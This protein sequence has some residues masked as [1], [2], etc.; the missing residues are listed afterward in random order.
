VV[1]PA[2]MAS[3]TRRFRFLS[4]LGS[5][6]FGEV[7]LAEMATSSGFEKKVA[8]KVLKAGVADPDRVSRR[9]RD[10]GRLLGLL[11]HP[12]IVRADDLVQLAGQPA[13]I[14]E[15]I[16]GA[17]LSALIDRRLCPTLL[18]SSVALY[19][20]RRVASALN[21]A[22]HSPSPTTGEPL[23]VLH[24]DIKPSNIRVT[25]HGEVKILDF[26]I[27]RSSHHAREA[28]TRDYQLGSMPYMAPEVMGGN[29]ASPASDVYS[30]GA[31][32]YELLGRSRLG[33]A[34]EL[35]AAHE[36][37]IGAAM[38]RLELDGCE[39][40]DRDELRALLEGMLLFDP[41]ARPDTAEVERRCRALERRIRGPSLEE[42]VAVA[43][44]S[45]RLPEPAVEASLVGR[46]LTEE[47]T[48]T[49]LDPGAAPSP[50]PPGSSPAPSGASSASAP[51]LRPPRG[52][53]WPPVVALLALL[54]LLAG[55]GAARLLTGRETGAP[56]P[57]HPSPPEA[58]ATQ[59]SPSG[60]TPPEPEPSPPQQEP[61]PAMEPAPLPPAP[62]PAASAPAPVTSKPASAPTEAPELTEARLPDEPTAAPEP[63]EVRL[64]SLPFG[65]QVSLDGRPLGETPQVLEIAPGPHVLRFEDGDHHFEQSGQVVQTGTLVYT[66]SAR[67]AV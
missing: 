39:G 23:R 12:A 36:A 18:P 45:L 59:L 22:Y 29:K 38:D 55:T 35:Q 8:V 51:A 16:P 41:E 25:P 48:A 9:L 60:P 61:E 65:L 10:E 52:P 26:G 53:G 11:Q 27:A 7:Y 40:A 21:A 37:Q 64:G 66:Q 34:G 17:N 1:P 47:L 46:E 33:W 54:L 5:G 13:V 30:L 28:I 32:L 62:S 43:F 3:P 56:D 2:S 15:Y 42:W 49:T 58:S 57:S 44:P 24:R 14:M 6:G 4:C 31:V 67:G 50:E 63:L 19:I 20:I